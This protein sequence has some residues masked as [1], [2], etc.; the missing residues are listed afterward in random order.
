MNTKDKKLIAGFVNGSQ[1]EFFEI[2][3]WISAIVKSEYWGLKDD[4]TDIVQDV[5]IKLYI[6]FQQ[7][8][9][10]HSSSLKTYVSRVTKYTCIDYL[11]KKYRKREVSIDAIDIEDSADT[12]KSMVLREQQEM[13]RAILSKI[14]ER[15]RRTLRL[16]FVEGLSYK[17]VA[18]IL[19]IA[20]G[21]VKSRV[22]RCIE[23]AILWRK[24]LLD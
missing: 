1:K 7:K 23:E 2:S 24:K 8:S 20:E 21:T 10:R 22:F 5:R 15:C 16:V 11:R 9:F 6:N 18:A 12:F 4:W 13:L 17:K 14:S 3:G 19:N